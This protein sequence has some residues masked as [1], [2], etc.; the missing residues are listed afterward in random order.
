MA[1]IPAARSPAGGPPLAPVIGGRRRV[2][3]CHRANLSRRFPANSLAAVREC[4]EAGVPRLEI[5]VRFLA[6]GALLVYHDATLDAESTGTGPVADVTRAEAAA[7]RYRAPGDHPIAFL[8]EIVAVMKGGSTRLQVDLKLPGEIAAAEV[9]ALSTALAPL[10][11]LVLI[12]SQAD[13]NVRPFA[14]RGFA[15][16]FDP[17]LYFHYSTRMPNPEMLPAERGVHGFW[18]DAPIAQR[19]DLDAHS[20]LRARMEEL[21]AVV[22]G[23][24]ELMVDIRT[25]LAM[26]ALGFRA[27]EELHRLGVELCAW[28]APD[29]G[30]DLTR[31]LL[32]DLFAIGADTITTDHPET[33][34]GYAANLGASFPPE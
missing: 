6:D 34:A 14:G 30:P 23:I 3:C 5:D 1:I 33:L 7:L 24:S 2:F 31:A 32:R 9:E 15:L 4:V 13:W 21:V 16:A 29:L 26:W 25:L 19:A 27:G 20:Y 8:E 11:P 18:D 22:P 12:G 10:V 17:M 28:T